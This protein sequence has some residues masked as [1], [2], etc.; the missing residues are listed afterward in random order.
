MNGPGIAPGSWRQVAQWTLPV[1]VIGLVA[2]MVIPLPPLLLD[3]LLSLDISISMVVL[4]S[5]VYIHSPS[6][7]SAFP[8]TLLLLTVFRLG[9]N[10]AT[11]RRILL[12]GPDGPD[13]ARRPEEAP[14]RAAS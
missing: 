11:T 1:G 7:F 5:A 12:H 10:I 4:L 13:A 2:V 6:K 14:N 8:S 9:L 3:L